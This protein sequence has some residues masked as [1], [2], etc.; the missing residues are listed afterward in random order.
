MKGN[1]FAV[2]EKQGVPVLMSSN[3]HA[4]CAGVAAD[5]Q[6]HGGVRQLQ[7]LGAR[8][9]RPARCDRARRRG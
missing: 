1:A 7:L 8:P 9:L 4:P 2:F 6:E 3:V 5:G